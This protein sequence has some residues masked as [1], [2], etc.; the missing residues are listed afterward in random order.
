ML[1]HYRED[2]LAYKNKHPPC[3]APSYREE[4]NR[5]ID[6]L[7][8]F[9]EWHS[10]KELQDEMDRWT[11][12]VPV[13]TFEN[14]WL[15]YKPGEPGYRLRD[16]G[17]YDPFIIK[18]VEGGLKSNNLSGYDIGLWNINS[19]GFYVGR[20]IDDVYIAPFDGEKDIS[21]LRF[22]PEKFY[23]EH[24]KDKQYHGNRPLRERLIARGKTFWDLI[25]QRSSYKEYNGKSAES[26]F[27]Q[28]RGGL[29]VL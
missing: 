3:H 13:C 5:H 12:D 14:L 20:S 6:L 1:V 9:L 26:P 16:P 25:K 15:L 21:S 11:R 2:L 28:V 18:V 24:E 17:Q 29:L 19:N 23:P 4:C 8:K 10:G 7:L 27:N 22:F